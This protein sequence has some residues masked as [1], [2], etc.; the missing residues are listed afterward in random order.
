MTERR[1]A[2][3]GIAHIDLPPG[4]S[5]RA[6]AI[7][8]FV[9]KTFPFPAPRSAAARAVLLSAVMLAGCAAPAKRVASDPLEPLNRAVYR[10]ND[11]AD[12]YAVKPVAKV[13]DTVIPRIVQRG[14]HNFFSNLDDVG[15]VVNDLLQGRLNNFGHDSVRLVA[16]SVFGVLGIVDVAS[17]RGIEKR[18][19]DFGQTLAVWGV[20]P[21]P[22]LVL[23]FLGPSTLRDGPAKFADSFIDPVWQIANVPERNVAVGLRLVDVRASLLPAERLLEQA[24]VDRYS[25]LRDAY[26]QRRLNL[27][28][29]GNPPRA[30]D[31]LE[32]PDA[33][34][35]EDLS[36]A[37]D[38]DL[39]GILPPSTLPLAVPD[40]VPLR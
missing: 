40:V 27:I 28:Y 9:R 1:Q 4:E 3:D 2:E 7:I 33:L 23:P 5:K 18:S 24:S 35:A 38:R 15:V 26:L 8:F 22:Y 13:Y 37:P 20:P 14:V 31:D 29:D 34:D 12:R 11:V 39:P 16:N 21:G 30:K 25:F 32:D 19:E 10:F 36:S 6:D 17:M